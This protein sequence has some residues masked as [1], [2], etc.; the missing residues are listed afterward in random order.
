MERLP[1]GIRPADDDLQSLCAL[2]GTRDMG[3]A[4]PRACG[5]WPIDRNTDDRLDARQGSPLGIGRKKG[6][7]KQAI[8]RSRGGR[9]TK[10][11]AIAD[12]KGRLLS[13]LLT[14]GQAHDCPPAKR[15]IRRAR[16]AKKLLATGRT[17]ALICANGSTSAAPRPSSQTGPI[18]NS[19][20]ASTE[21][22]TN[23]VTAS[24]MPSVASRTSGVSPPATIDSPETSSPQSASSLLSYGG[25]YE[26]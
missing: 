22:H 19:P 24:R 16:P 2:G 13:I 20:S 11:H 15:L 10:I 1:A 17:T 7:N 25:L 26:S 21:N 14:G 23:S 12:A 5:A 18:A 6:E 4:V 3:A 9:N 8:G